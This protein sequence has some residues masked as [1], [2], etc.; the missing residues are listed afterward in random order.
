MPIGAHPSLLGPASY[1]QAGREDELSFQ[2]GDYLE[3]VGPGENDDWVEVMRVNGDVKA[4]GLAPTTYLQP[5]VDETSFTADS[6]YDE[7]AAPSNVTRQLSPIL[8]IPPPPPE[9][10][11]DESVSPAQSQPDVSQD[12]GTSA[13]PAATPKRVPRVSVAEVAGAVDKKWAGLVTQ[14]PSAA[15]GAEEFDVLPAVVV[16]ETLEQL[17]PSRSSN[18]PR[19]SINGRPVGGGDALSDG[20][21]GSSDSGIGGVTPEKSNGAAGQGG[22]RIEEL[23]NDFTA[24]QHVRSTGNFEAKSHEEVSLYRGDWVALMGPGKTTDFVQVSFPDGQQGDVPK[25]LLRACGS[26]EDGAE[27]CEWCSSLSM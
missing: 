17:P 14:Q 19:R 21:N 15:D 9:E 13:S 20:V 26:V 10:E 22:D 27:R 3:L 18:T 8:T 4:V 25:A 5:A 2:A 23:I 16:E 12:M 24:C 11:E 6:K 1:V 7:S